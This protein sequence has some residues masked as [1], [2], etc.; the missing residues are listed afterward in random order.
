MSPD[1][2]G[3]LGGLVADRRAALALRR[4]APVLAAD[5]MFDADGYRHR[6]MAGQDGDPVR[7]YLDTGRLGGAN[8]HPLFDRDWYREAHQG[9]TA[10]R[11]DPFVHYA[12]WGR[13]AGLPPNPFFDPAWYRAHNPDL[14]GRDPVR[15]WMEQGAAE[16][17]DPSAAFSTTWYMG[18]NADVAQSGGNPLVH[19]LQYGRHEARAPL[20]YAIDW[21]SA[22]PV[23]AA[24]IGCR[25][26]ATPRP[27]MALLVTHS[28]DATLKPHLR[29][30]LE[31]LA[32]E[33]IGVT[34]VVAAD[35]GFS[36]EPWLDGLVDGLY[37]RQNQGWDFACWAHLHRLDEAYVQCER[38]FW[39]NDSVVGPVNG[40]AFG[41][42][43]QRVR[44][45]PADVIGLTANH[46]DGRHL[47]SYFLAFGRPALAS[48]A[49]RGFVEGVQALRSKRDVI[50]AYETRLS[51]TLEAA[52]LST[53]ALFEP[54]PALN[55]TLHDWQ[56]LLEDGFA[57]LKV[58]A[59][60]AGPPEAEP[61]WRAALRRH[62]YDATLADRLL[63][64]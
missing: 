27:E 61:A 16:G 11:I 26:R 20:P 45:D 43:L 30:Y 37:V 35:R 36:A 52:G 56:A 58:G 46:E 13:A 51:P 44:S 7:H 64:G 49:F 15:H 1:A 5:P 50:L 54:N 38:L 59:M 8:P 10:A 18:H 57:F 19:F 62:G 2:L 17:R 48:A 9:G 14:A 40:A 24:T 31:C 6:Y 55:P 34:L 3:W 53:A 47:Q 21:A 41:A 22:V 29:H 12:L 60:T 42:L 32:A 28:A 23:T 33:G 25:K 63:A 4:A 39:L